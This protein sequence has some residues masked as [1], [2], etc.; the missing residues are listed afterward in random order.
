MPKSKAADGVAASSL[1]AEGG[2]VAGDDAAKQAARKGAR[3]PPLAQRLETQLPAGPTPTTAG[4]VYV[5]HLPHGFYE[6]AIRGFFAQF[7]RVTRVRV[8]RS[9]K[10]ARAKGYAFVE[11]S[12]SEVSSWVGCWELAASWTAS[13]LRRRCPPARPLT[14][15]R[16]LPLPAP[17]LPARRS[18]ASSPRR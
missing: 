11:F 15:P 18:L 2:K 13:V 14:L 4:V 10:T 7:G 8:A 5:G 12:N 1:A 6:E 3:R 17:R 16:V 9:K